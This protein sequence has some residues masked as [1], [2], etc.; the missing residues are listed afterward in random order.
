[1]KGCGIL[2]FL[3]P[4]IPGKSENENENE[5]EVIGKGEN[6]TNPRQFTANQASKRLSKAVKKLSST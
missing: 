1:V 2:H 3:D 6:T 5:N 4:P